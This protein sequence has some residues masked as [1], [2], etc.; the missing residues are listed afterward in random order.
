MLAQK[1][2]TTPSRKRGRHDSKGAEVEPAPK[3]QRYNDPKPVMQAGICQD[4]KNSTQI[5][6]LEMRMQ[7]V[8]SFL[9]EKGMEHEWTRDETRS[10]LS[11]IVNR[12]SSL[13]RFL[14]ISP[15]FPSMIRHN[16]HNNMVCP[17]R[18]CGLELRDMESLH[19]H[20]RSNNGR[21]HRLLRALLTRTHCR[22]C[23]RTFANNR[24]LA[25]H[26]FRAHGV[27]FGE[28]RF[29]SLL[30]FFGVQ[31]DASLADSQISSASGSAL[32]THKQQTIE[33]HHSPSGQNQQASEGPTNLEESSERATD[34]G[35]HNR[36]SDAGSNSTTPDESITD[37]NCT[38]EAHL[39][40]TTSNVRHGS[41]VAEAMCTSESIGQPGSYGMPAENLRGK[42]TSNIDR[43]RIPGN[44]GIFPGMTTA[45]DI[46]AIE[47]DR[48][49]S[50]D[51]FAA[52]PLSNTVS[53][54]SF[55]FNNSPQHLQSFDT[56]SL[57][58]GTDYVHTFDYSRSLE[59]SPTSPERAATSSLHNS[60]GSWLQNPPTQASFPARS[61]VDHMGLYNLNKHP[62]IRPKFPDTTTANSRRV[63]EGFA[64][65]ESRAVLPEKSTANV[66]RSLNK[67]RLPRDMR[68]APANVGMKEKNVIPSDSTLQTASG[69]N[70]NPALNHQP[71]HMLQ[72]N[73]LNEHS[74][75]PQWNWRGFQEYQ[76]HQG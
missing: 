8:E 6:A 46:C 44:L 45:G 42:N 21:E 69:L 39:A 15:Q 66:G 38:L 22:I 26:E 37:D 64:L 60:D 48:L 2:P 5:E 32:D 34:N 12:V 16:Q 63:F 43:N 52:F 68:T 72:H 14:G 29:N 11:N 57:G 18:D 10:S 75:T 65:P 53:G 4:W 27:P 28:Q 7:E 49:P 71:H 24:S 73:L 62:E 20:I 54:T 51:T 61:T 59:T 3:H 9:A 76:F 55:P 17:A 19:R 74:N 13:E 35:A 23:D 67:E 30:P 33:L 58:N 56:T 70:D 36:D 47:K 41:T 1:L 25:C 40:L 31:E 50:L